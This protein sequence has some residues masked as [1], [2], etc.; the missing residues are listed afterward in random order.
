MFITSL[1]FYIIILGSVS[2]NILNITGFLS[3]VYAIF[4]EPEV[5]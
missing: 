1:I 3:S 4:I 5:A 2:L